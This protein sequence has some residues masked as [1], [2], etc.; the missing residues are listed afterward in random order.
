[1]APIKYVGLKPS[2][3][4]TVAETGLSWA[5]G[6]IQF[7]PPWAVA[8]LTYHTDTWRIATDEELEEAGLARPSE[9]APQQPKPQP[10]L[11]EPESLKV[12]MPSIA[13]MSKA[14]LAQLAMQRFGQ[15]LDP[16]MKA[17]DMRAQIVAWENG[18]HQRGA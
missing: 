1:M 4:D 6:E 14:S 15:S 10:E 18:G 2:V 9:T 17:A 13:T 11:D 3:Y 8:R 12:G 16:S 7:V 5:N